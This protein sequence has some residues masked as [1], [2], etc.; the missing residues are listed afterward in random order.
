MTLATY[1]KSRSKMS[2][3]HWAVI[4]VDANDPDNWR[5]LDQSIKDRIM[6][7]IDAAEETYEREWSWLRKHWFYMVRLS[8]LS[9]G[10]PDDI[11]FAWTEEVSPNA[12]GVMSYIDY[13]K[14]VRGEHGMVETR[15]ITR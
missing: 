12:T 11:M 10:Q 5:L 3:L 13:A 14:M 8:L 4:W 15:P 1:E 2:N 6:E 9:D 7:S